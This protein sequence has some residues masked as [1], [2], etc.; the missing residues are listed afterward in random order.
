MRRWLGKRY[1]MGGRSSKKIKEGKKSGFNS[2]E[3]QNAI[4]TNT[5]KLTVRSVDT[6][7]G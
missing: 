2:T 1:D 4:G 5:T 7:Y 3:I 6:S